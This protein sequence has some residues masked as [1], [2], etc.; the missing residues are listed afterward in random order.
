MIINC[1]ECI[2]TWVSVLCPFILSFSVV[3]QRRGTVLHNEMKPRP[4]LNIINIL[5]S[6]IYLV[7]AQFNESSGHHPHAI[8]GDP[9]HGC[10]RHDGGGSGE[11][12]VGG[13]VGGGVAGEGGK[14]AQ[15]YGGAVGEAVARHG[16]LRA[17]DPARHP[18]V[19]STGRDILVMVTTLAIT[20]R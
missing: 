13:G 20:S 8:L 18:V 10:Y 5:I 15:R 6:H 3:Q 1:G 14:V 19:G 16:D 4:R 7:W 2:I 11:A 12:A 17:P 9:R